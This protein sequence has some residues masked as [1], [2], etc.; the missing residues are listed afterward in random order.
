MISANAIGEIIEVYLKH[1][2][3]LRRILLSASLKTKIEVHLSHLIDGVQVMN[4]DIDAAWFSR[5]PKPGG[6][7][8]E[9]RHLSETP[10]SLVEKVDEDSI[11]FEATLRAVELRL[12][13]T[14]LI[15]KSA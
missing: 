8:W 3:I 9:I 6:V 12:R 11:D 2:W 13:E 15:R 1:G 7:V 5:P 10:Y 14:L 4:F